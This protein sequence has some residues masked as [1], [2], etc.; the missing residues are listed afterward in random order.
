MRLELRAF[1]LIL[2]LGCSGLFGPC[3]ESSTGNA[4]GM[5]GALQDEPD[6]QEGLIPGA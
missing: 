2:T 3:F 4:L 6:S 1:T 5:L